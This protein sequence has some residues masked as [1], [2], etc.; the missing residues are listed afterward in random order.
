M[1][2][3]YLGTTAILGRESATAQQVAGY[4]NLTYLQVQLAGK[5]EQYF[6]RFCDAALT[7]SQR[8]QHW[9]RSHWNVQAHVLYDKAPSFFQPASADEVHPQASTFHGS[10]RARTLACHAPLRV[11]LSH[12]HACLSDSWY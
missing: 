6:A 7:V 1:S 5:Q 12:V 9:L 8:F 4:E 2:V 11:L 10:P 3:E